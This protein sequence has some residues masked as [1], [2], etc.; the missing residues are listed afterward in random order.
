MRQ[1]NDTTPLSFATYLSAT[2]RALLTLDRPTLLGTFSGKDDAKALVRLGNGDIREM[3]VG[4]HI[5]QSRIVSVGGAYIDLALM[6]EHHR[7][8]MPA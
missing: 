4:D 2:E 3:R 8:T 7:L 6:G 1:D 5:G